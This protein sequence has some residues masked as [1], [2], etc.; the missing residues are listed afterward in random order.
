MWD[1]AKIWGAR[2]AVLL[3]E[4]RQGSCI[5]TSIQPCPISS[6]SSPP[7]SFSHPF[8][9]ALMSASSSCWWHWSFWQLCSLA[10]AW[11]EFHSKPLHVL[12]LSSSYLGFPGGAQHQAGF[13]SEQGMGHGHCSGMNEVE[14]CSDI[15]W[16]PIALSLR[17]L[18]LSLSVQRVTESGTPKPIGG[19]GV[20][21]CTVLCQHSVKTKYSHPEAVRVLEKMHPQG[22]LQQGHSLLHLPSHHGASCEL[23]WS[24]AGHVPAF[25]WPSL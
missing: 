23:Y 5:T 1:R 17:V 3:R 14:E 6:I 2:Q 24:S 21:Q 4:L 10:K 13:C 7:P 25:P 12:V 18:A 11:Q 20:K 9:W 15:P 22:Q 19:V 8:I 16:H